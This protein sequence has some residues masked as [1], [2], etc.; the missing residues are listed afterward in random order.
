MKSAQF[1]TGLKT[2][3]LNDSEIKELIIM[4]KK[5]VTKPPAKIYEKR[6]SIRCN[7]DLQSLDPQGKF[8]SVFIRQSIKFIEDFSIGLCYKENVIPDIKGI[9]A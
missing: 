6:S 3:M 7:L 5:I 8:F 9:A 1:K 4:P 2:K